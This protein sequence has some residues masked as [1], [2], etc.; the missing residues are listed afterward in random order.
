[1]CDNPQRPVW[2]ILHLPGNQQGLNKWERSLFEIWV[3]AI[4]PLHKKRSIL[5]HANAA[6]AEVTWSCAADKM[7]KRARHRHPAEDPLTLL[8]GLLD[9][10]SD[11]ICVAQHEGQFNQAIK[12]LIWVTC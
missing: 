3:K 7:S 2:P 11:S 8:I 6:W 5:V 1:M 12:E 10:N 9:A 4:Q